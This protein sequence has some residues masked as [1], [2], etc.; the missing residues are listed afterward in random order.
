MKQSSLIILQKLLAVFLLFLL[1]PIN[2]K[3]FPKEMLSGTEIVVLEMDVSV[4][5][6]IISINHLYDDI[7]ISEL[8]VLYNY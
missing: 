5:L 8:M 7:G 1:K 3:Q 2:T 6:L 4:S